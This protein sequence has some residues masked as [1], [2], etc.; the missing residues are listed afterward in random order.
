M[1]NA[2]RIE[3][4]PGHSTGDAFFLTGSATTHQGTVDTD[5]DPGIYKL[6][7]NKAAKKWAINGANGGLRFFVEL[8]GADPWAINYAASLRL[9]VIRKGQILN[10][11]E[12]LLDGV[13]PNA[14]RNDPKYI[15]RVTAG[16]YD[17]ATGKFTVDHED[18]STVE[19]DYDAIVKHI[20]QP[21]AGGATMY[22]YYRNLQNYKIYPRLF[23][24][25]TAPNIV[26]M[27]LETEQARPSAE[28]LAR[29]GRFL[30]ELVKVRGSASAV[31]HVASKVPAQAAEATWKVVP[32]ASARVVR[33]MVGIAGNP[34][35]A[36]LRLPT[37][38]LLTSDILAD[39]T[40]VTYR[41][42]EII[43]YF[44]EKGTIRAAHRAMLTAAAQ[45]A[46]RLGHRTFK[47]LGKQANP[48][49]R[50]HADKLARQVGVANS[51]KEVS[52]GIPGAMFG[53]YEVT[54][55]VDRVLSTNLE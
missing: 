47:L 16:H 18:G 34:P 43:A 35:A 45:E 40:G 23:D 5:L 13:G 29:L 53:D 11:N 27:V 8:D 41:V 22:V 42:A 37:G 54:L 24:K 14:Y 21:N 31:G 46:R 39:R 52:Q 30:L 15:D 48:N 49:F 1:I 25:N 28:G 10:P 33:Q 7:V 6:T 20:Q 9:E 4:L 12:D 44:A 50:K 17:V 19:L 55:R 51:G 3:L 2:I 26:S 36:R 38:D 32:K